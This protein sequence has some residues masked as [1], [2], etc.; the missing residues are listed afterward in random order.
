M[1]NRLPIKG[2]KDGLLIS[3][4]DGEWKKV[5]KALIDQIEEKEEFFKGAKVTLDIGERSLKAAELGTLRDKLSEQGVTLFALLSQSASTEAVAETLGLSTHK[6]VLR[7]DTAGIGKAV[8]GGESAILIRRTLRS[9]HS[10]K[11]DGHVIVA[12]DVNPGAEILSTG[13]IYVWGKL[14]GS[15]SAGIDGSVSEVICSLQLNPQILRIANVNRGTGKSVIK[16]KK[17][18]EMAVLKDGEIKIIEWDQ[19]SV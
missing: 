6:S 16:I 5:Q 18:P 9:G 19:K 13:S 4:G 8:L 17:R 10:V 11:Y 3:V 12:G 7:G 1:T 15:A 2:Y 14:N